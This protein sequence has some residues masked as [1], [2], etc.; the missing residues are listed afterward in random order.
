MDEKKDVLEVV[1]RE[2]E[3][4]LKE[5]ARNANIVLDADYGINLKDNPGITLTIG[6][7]Y[8]KALI[9][10]LVVSK[11]KDVAA[12]VNFLNLFDIGI[13]YRENEDAEKEGNYA[14]FLTPLQSAI[15]LAKEQ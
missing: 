1:L 14:P 7:V 5:I 10:Q 6:Y 2:K 13:S 15:N 4:E 9:E 3:D 11:S 8:M 12:Q